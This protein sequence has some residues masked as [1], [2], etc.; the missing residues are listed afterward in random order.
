[1]T[2]KEC[3]FFLPKKEFSKILFYQ[4]RWYL[5][6][7]LIILIL[8][9]VDGVLLGLSL[10]TEINFLYVYPIPFL[11]IAEGIIYFFAITDGGVQIF[12]KCKLV[13]NGNGSLTL[14]CLRPGTFS[15]GE[16]AGFS[17]TIRVKSI[18]EKGEYWIILGEK[19]QW[20]AVPKSIPVTSFLQESNPQK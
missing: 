12:N 9:I 7:S 8:L 19:R 5:L 10:L 2:E 16:E 3:E 15:G 18:K 11:A 4:R 20:A 17:K 14:S 13:D 6:A 1:M